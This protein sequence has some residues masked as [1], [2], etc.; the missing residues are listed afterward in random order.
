MWPQQSCLVSRLANCSMLAGGGTCHYGGCVMMMMMM[1]PVPLGPG[2][3]EAV[4]RPAWT[5][6]KVAL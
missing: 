2:W 6:G 4:I 1:F 3:P 5:L